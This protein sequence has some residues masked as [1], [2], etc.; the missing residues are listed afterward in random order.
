VTNTNRNGI[1]EVKFLIEELEGARAAEM[2]CVHIEAALEPETEVSLPKK[3]SLSTLVGTPVL[4]LVI[5]VF[6]V[7][8]WFLT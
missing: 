2:S 6:G 4:V 3:M 1:G 7:V 5:L 8:W